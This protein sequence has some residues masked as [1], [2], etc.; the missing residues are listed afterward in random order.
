MKSNSWETM[1]TYHPLGS[2]LD[3]HTKRMKVPGGW[4]VSIWHKD[5]NSSSVAIV[6]VP[7]SEHVWEIK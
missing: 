3:Q 5:D 4:L 1:E 2:G 7:D 6:F